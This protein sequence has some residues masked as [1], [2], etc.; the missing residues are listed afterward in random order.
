MPCLRKLTREGGNDY[1]QLKPDLDWH[2]PKDST[3]FGYCQAGRPCVRV[4][5]LRK[6]R[7][8]TIKIPTEALSPTGAVI[9]GKFPDYRQRSPCD[10]PLPI[11]DALGGGGTAS[12]SILWLFVTVTVAFCAATIVNKVQTMITCSFWKQERE[13][14]I[15]LQ[16][17]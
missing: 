5:E 9:F 14:S 10:G 12:F 1:T 15:Q 17:Q 3:L 16:K 13:F 8:R 4:Q 2:Q 7:L 6:P 11:D